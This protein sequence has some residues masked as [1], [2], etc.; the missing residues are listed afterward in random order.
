MD[1]QGRIN[2][3]TQTKA[4][5]VTTCI[6]AR[7]CG[8]SKASFEDYM[9]RIMVAILSLVYMH[10]CHAEN[11][12]V[13]EIIAYK[14]KIAGSDIFMTLS[15]TEGDIVGGYRYTKYGTDIPVQGSIENNHMTLTERTAVSE[16]EI[17]A[18]INNQLVQGLWKSDSVS[19]SFHVSALSK[20]YKN[21]ISGVEI[22]KNN[23]STDIAIKFLDGRSQ[24]FEIETLTNTT[25][26]VFE[27]L[28]FDGLPDLRVLESTTGPN[29]T[30]IAW[31]YEPS[32]KTFEYSEEMSILSSPK[33][34]HSEK[35]ILSL[36]RDGCCRYIASKSVENEK[37]SAEFEYE[38]LIGVERVIDFKTNTTTTNSIRKEYFE[39]KYLTPMGAEGL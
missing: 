39:R 16:A 25:L 20:S 15:E 6:T 7:K 17:T 21:L 5:N 24:N 33:V 8:T 32:E 34:L 19:H 28:N 3:F 4:K 38:K 12:S 2:Q 10:V 26:I 27:D 23:L 29:R 36:S 11:M 13:T 35:A 1:G 18:E 9:K 37:H 31:T 30:Y 22:S 14:G